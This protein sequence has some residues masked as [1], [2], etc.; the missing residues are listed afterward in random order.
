[1]DQ[2]WHIP[3]ASLPIEQGDILLS[4]NVTTGGLN[5]I[6]VVV[7]AD[8]DIA[9]HKFGTNLACLRIISLHDYV[10]NIWAYRKLTRVIEIEG[11]KMA[12][13]INKW[14]SRRMTDALPLEASVVIGWIRDS[15]PA[16]ICADLAIPETDV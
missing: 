16:Q 13:L 15:E 6:A 5:D 8:C 3:H 4:R 11:T 9:H 14:N 10:R 7:T 2:E 1:M 12:Q